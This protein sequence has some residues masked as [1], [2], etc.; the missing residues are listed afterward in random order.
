M[1]QLPRGVHKAFLE[2]PRFQG[3]KLP[4]GSKGSTLKSKYQKLLSHN[5]L[6]LMSRML[7][8]ETDGRASG[9]DCLAHAVFH[10]LRI[11]DQSI[12]LADTDDV[13]RTAVAR[14][15]MLLLSSFETCVCGALVAFG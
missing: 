2:N 5:A 7:V 11:T 10:S 3:T 4:L 12:A 9:K 15:S 14:L 8:M 13:R 6:D 1:G